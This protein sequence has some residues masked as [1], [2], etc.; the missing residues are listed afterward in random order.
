MIN[1]MQSNQHVLDTIRVAEDSIWMELIQDIQSD[2][3]ITILY[4]KICQISTE[5]N[6]DLKY[7]MKE[8]FHYIIRC[9]QDLISF[10]LLNCIENVVHSEECNEMYYVKYSLSQMKALCVL[11]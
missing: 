6:M 1:F 10:Q 5:Y 3:K 9:R 2:L 11:P 7:V 4:Q 8:L